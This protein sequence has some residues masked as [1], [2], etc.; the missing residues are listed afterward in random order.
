MP[1]PIDSHTKTYLSLAALYNATDIQLELLHN[2]QPVALRN[3]QAEI[4][5]TA[6][7]GTMYRRVVA[8]VED[9]SHTQA[10]YPR[11]ALSSPG[12]ICKAYIITDSAD[13]FDAQTTGTTCP[14]VRN[15]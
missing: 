4:D 10:P 1:R 12:S 7:A 14:D 15:P 5:V 3:V 13:E 9:A 8:R 11:A 2:G 6:R